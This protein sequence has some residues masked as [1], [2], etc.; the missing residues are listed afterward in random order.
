MKKIFLSETIMLRAL[1]F[2][3]KQHLVD[4]FQV[5]SNNAL[6]AENGLPQVS[7]GTWSAF[8]RFLYVSFKQ[9][10]GERFCAI[11][12]SCSCSKTKLIYSFLKICS[13]PLISFARNMNLN[14]K[15]IYQEQ[16]R[17]PPHFE[18]NLSCFVIDH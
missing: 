1:I 2:G 16:E 14:G 10:S 17:T 15:I 3:M 9:N 7:P 5:C 18:T 12:P 4:L 13:M 11:C 6:W 8:N